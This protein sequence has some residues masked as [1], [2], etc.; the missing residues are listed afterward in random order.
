MR[1]GASCLLK[2]VKPVKPVLPRRLISRCAAVL[3]IGV[4]LA[5]VAW[6]QYRF[7]NWTT[8]QGLPQNSVLAITQTRDGY[9]W[10]ATYNGLVR[11]D[12]VRFT[13]FDK[14]NTPAFKTNRFENLFED[15]T[16]TLW[17]SIEDGGLIRYQ[18]GVFTPL[19]VEQGLPSN[20]VLNLQRT[21]DGAL[22][23][24]TPQGAVWW[25]NNQPVAYE[26]SSATR[27]DTKVYLGPSGT[28]WSTDKNGLHQRSNDGRVTHYELPGE[29]KFL[30]SANML[31]DRSGA[32]WVA[33]LQ[34][35]VFKVE[36]GVLTDYT[37]RLG[38]SNP[39]GILRILEDADGSLWF[40]TLNS[41][42]IHFSNDAAEKVVAY[43]TADGLSSNGIRGL[44]KDHEGTLWIGTAGGGLNRMTRQFISGYS[45]AQGLAGN[46]AH[47]VLADRAGSV[48]V[49]T[50]NGLSRITNG[51]ITNYRNAPSPGSLPLHG[52]QSL[53]EDRSGRLWIGG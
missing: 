29:P 48:W 53:Y 15:P 8:E 37:K 27:G 9:L 5:G 11:F 26:H 33:P 49:G 35:G 12:G 30:P 44:Y 38:L 32:L 13:V 34:H 36:H 7:D 40:A 18:N 39:I 45:E 46:V 24:S 22:F 50:H 47:A 19:T 28:H 14:N 41:G 4:L 23:I 3:L 43:T 42:L 6:G 52:I 10:L 31:E 2:P 16:G 17:L 25:R 20:T 51:A 21:P 1:N